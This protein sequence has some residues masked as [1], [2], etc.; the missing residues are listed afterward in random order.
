ML[1]FR[2]RVPAQFEPQNYVA[3]DARFAIAA[4]PALGVDVFSVEDR[5]RPLPPPGMTYDP[6][7]RNTCQEAWSSVNSEPLLARFDG[8][9]LSVELAKIEPK[10]ENFTF[11]GGK[12]IV[13]CLH[14]A[15]L[16]ASRV[17][18]TLTRP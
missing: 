3:G 14:L 11:E 16:K 6:R 8:T 1:E 10:T 17:I 5:I 15:E 7:S 13:G 12:R 18:N 2:V 4:E 9:R